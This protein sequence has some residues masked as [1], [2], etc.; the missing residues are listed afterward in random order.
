MSF[1]A[2]DEDSAGVEEEECATGQAEGP[3]AEAEERGMED[4][5]RSR[6]RAES[7]RAAAD[8]ES[9]GMLFRGLS[10]LEPSPVDLSV[11]DEACIGQPG[12]GSIPAVDGG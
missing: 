10:W 6:G 11:E 7:C 2:A 4:R 5:V 3:A 8:C 9:S 12:G 1:A